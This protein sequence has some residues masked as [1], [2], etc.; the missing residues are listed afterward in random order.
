MIW[1]LF[2]YFDVYNVLHHNRVGEFRMKC[3]DWMQMNQIHEMLH[4][5]NMV[6]Y[7]SINAYHPHI[8]LILY[9][10]NHT[11]YKNTASY[12]SYMSTYSFKNTNVNAPAH[13][14]KQM[15]TKWTAYNS[16]IL[17]RTHNFHFHNKNAAT[18]F[19]RQTQ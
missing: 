19:Q 8:H 3:N 6:L 13:T 15:T 9:V 1:I 10:W 5:F 2:I 7:S 12:S 14:H 4:P 17:H 18:R 16:S 11:Y